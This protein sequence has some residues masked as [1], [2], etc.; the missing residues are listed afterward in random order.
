ML[1]ILLQIFLT[2][3]SSYL[4]MPCFNTTNIGFLNRFIQVNYLSTIFVGVV[5]F[6]SLFKLVFDLIFKKHISFIFDFAILVF[7]FI[8]AYMYIF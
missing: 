1:F 8:L 5:I 4:L 2:L 7:N 3:F 6:I